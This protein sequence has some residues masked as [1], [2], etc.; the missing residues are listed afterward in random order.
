[1]KIVNRSILEM[2]R[3]MVKKEFWK[4][5]IER[6]LGAGRE[7]DVIIWNVG[8]NTQNKGI[9]KVWIKEEKSYQDAFVKQGIVKKTSNKTK[10]EMIIRSKTLF[11]RSRANLQTSFAN[12]IKHNKLRQVIFCLYK[13]YGIKRSSN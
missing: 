5:Q 3:T 6:S 12:S 8:L 1:M 9:I 4:E 11:M 7:K 2:K 10:Q 13:K